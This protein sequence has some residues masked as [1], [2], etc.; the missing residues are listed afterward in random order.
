MHTLTV[1]RLDRAV[2]FLSVRLEQSP[3]ENAA[4]VS[5]KFNKEGKT[6]SAL[7]RQSIR[8]LFDPFGLFHAA[9]Q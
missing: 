4:K 7:V 9:E 8:G 6:K 2:L 5:C 1:Q 3:V